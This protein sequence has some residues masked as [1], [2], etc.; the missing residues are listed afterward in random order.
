M[1]A[2]LSATKFVLLVAVE[3]YSR[4]YDWG[5]IALSALAAFLVER[6]CEPTW[7]AGWS[8]LG[9]AL[10]RIS[11]EETTLRVLLAQR[12]EQLETVDAL[13]GFFDA[14]SRLVVDAEAHMEFDQEATLLDSESIF[15]IFVRRCCL[16]FD[17]LEFHHISEFLDECQGAARALAGTGDGEAELKRSRLELQEHVEH[18]IEALERGA[19]APLAQDMERRIRHAAS[20]LSDPSRLHFLN[21]LNLVRQGESQQSEASLR[22]FFDSNC[23]NRTVY[24]HAL[25]YL[26]AMRV[27]LGIHDAAHDALAEATHVARDCQDHECLLFIS[28]WEARLLLAKLRPAPTPQQTQSATAAIN[29]LIEKATAMQSPELMATGYLLLSELHLATNAGPRQVFECLVCAQALAI[30]HNVQRAGCRL[31]L[32]Q[33]WQQ[34]GNPWLAQLNA[35]LA[36]DPLTDREAAQ[37]QRLLERARSQLSFGMCGQLAPAASSTL[38]SDLQAAGGAD[39]LSSHA[40]QLET[41]RLLMDDGYE[42]EARSLLLEIS[43]QSGVADQ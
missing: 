13:H 14:M 24:Q 30:E 33:A 34:F 19:G 5:P 2:Y 38:A 32:A 1:S 37:K 40:R 27:Q 23:D 26:A 35:Q 12:I 9:T 25:L 42:C 41:A 22:R 10:D 18:L 4:H 43:S 3:Q 31:A 39:F 17:Q 6:L 21:Y 28:C 36:H 15:G 7:T 8:E 29:T 11:A 20:Q 16:A